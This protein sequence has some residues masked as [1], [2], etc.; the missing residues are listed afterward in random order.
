MVL[1]SQVMVEPSDI[2]NRLPLL[3]KAYAKAHGDYSALE[4][5]YIFHNLYYVLEANGIRFV[6]EGIEDLTGGVTT[7]LFSTDILDK[8]KFWREELMNVNKQ[9]LFGCGQMNGAYGQRSGIIEKHA[10]SVMEAREETGLVEIN[11]KLEEKTVRLV[12]LR[13]PWGSGGEWEGAWSDGSA[14]WSG[15]WLSKLK[16]K[17]GDDGV[18]Y[19]FDASSNRG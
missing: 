1:S 6:G 15:E 10:Y 3:E 4:S 8:E 11:G 9:F 18:C 5:G 7:E 19:A 17:F 13:N 16:H 2:L 12:K 14:E